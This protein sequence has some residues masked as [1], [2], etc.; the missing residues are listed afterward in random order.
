MQVHNSWCKRINGSLSRTAAQLAAACQGERRFV[1]GVRGEAGGYLIGEWRAPTERPQ[2]LVVPELVAGEGAARRALLGF[3]AAQAEQADAVLLDTPP[4]D[5]LAAL[6]S[7]DRP[8]RS[9]EHGP[10]EHLSAATLFDGA[11]ARLVDLER[12][13]LGRGYPDGERTRVAFVE[14][15]G[16]PVTLVV[17]DG[18]RSVVPGRAAGVPLVAG[19]IAELTRILVGAIGLAAAARLGLVTVEP[20]GAVPRI[21]ALLALPPPYPLVVY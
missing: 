6:L 9:D 5:P 17:D 19:T 11:M 13:L 10:D 1:V 16:E 2:L 15:P 20:E 3:V 14:R 21:D 4:G 8:A 12:A 18:R 7:R